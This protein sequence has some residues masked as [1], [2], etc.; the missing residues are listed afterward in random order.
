MQDEMAHNGYRTLTI[1]QRDLTVP[2]FTDWQARYE[3]A[4]VGLCVGVIWLL[5]G[6]HGCALQANDCFHVIHCNVKAG[7][8]MVLCWQALAVSTQLHIVSLLRPPMY[9]MSLL[10]SE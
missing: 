6:I 10:L 1:A 9:C 2:E 5:V 7:A 3:D 8:E 4:Q